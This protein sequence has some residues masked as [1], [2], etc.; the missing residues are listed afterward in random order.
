MPF[1]S[2]PK[3]ATNLKIPDGASGNVKCP[4]CAAI[5][6]VAAKPAAAPAFEVVEDVP[7]PAPKRVAKPEVLQ[8]DFDVVEDPKPKKK[9]VEADYDDEDDR[10]R[11]KRRRDYDDEE[12]D[13]P[14]RKKGHR[15]DYE[16]E[17]DWQPAGKS[18]AGSAK[19]GMLML[20]ISLWLYFATFAVLALFMLIAWVGGYISTGL[21]VIPGITGLA[22]WVC[23]AVGLGFSIAGPARSRGLAIAATAVAGVHLVLSFVIANNTDAGLF[24]DRTVQ[25]VG[26]MNK[27]S[28]ARLESTSTTD[29][30]ER[31]EKAKEVKE[32]LEEH[33]DELQDL[34]YYE[35]KLRAKGGEERESVRELKPP[36]AMRW[37]DLSTLIPFA[38]DFI[39]VLSYHNKLFGDYVFG[40]LGG[41]IEVA[42]LVLIVLLIGSLSRALKGHEAA[43]RAKFG[44]IAVGV[45]IGV[46]MLISV[47]VTMMID[48]AKEDQK[49]A[50]ENNRPS[51]S[52]MRQDPSSIETAQKAAR[53]KV[54]SAESTMKHSAAAGGL[55]T[56]LLYA[57]MLILPIIAAHGAYS[58][59]ARRAR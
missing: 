50:W 5:F 36:S 17:D 25:V 16:E 43:D 7:S 13:R 19:V 4:K 2:C 53:E 1:V 29:A 21:M 58:V 39:A 54:R 40:L 14:R 15:R 27:A 49:K 55:L 3:C 56:N 52:E 31:A 42:R 37:S 32:F 35:A 26:L 34:T 38:D 59:A 33:K 6:P 48:N 44:L 20:V 9:V 45:G 8:P 51:A 10:P 23:A 11:S 22:N 30:K 47:L 24:S 41:L 46:A 28:A 12:D 18:G 57:G